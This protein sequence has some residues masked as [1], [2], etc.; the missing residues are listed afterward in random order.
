MTANTNTQPDALRLADLID[1]YNTGVCSQAIYEDYA[2]AAAELRRLHAECEALRSVV[3][4]LLSMDVRGYTLAD[5]LQFT[6]AGRSILD[7][8]RAAGEMQ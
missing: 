5:R 7:A 8:A 3:D 2:R 1:Q 4:R 6:T